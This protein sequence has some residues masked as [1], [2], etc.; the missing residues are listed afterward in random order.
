MWSSSP[1]RKEENEMK[2]KEVWDHGWRNSGKKRTLTEKMGKTAEKY[3]GKTRTENGSRFLVPWTDFGSKMKGFWKKFV[4]IKIGKNGLTKNSRKTER[5]TEEFFNY[6]K[7][8]RKSNW[9]GC[10]GT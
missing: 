3:K 2:E 6:K 7:P 4:Y 10:F 8:D 1:Y 9:K 5:K